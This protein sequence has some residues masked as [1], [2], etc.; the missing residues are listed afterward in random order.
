MFKIKTIVF[1]ILAALTFIKI[2]SAGH[3]Q[4]TMMYGGSLLI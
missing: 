2:S 3:H 4:M 1:T